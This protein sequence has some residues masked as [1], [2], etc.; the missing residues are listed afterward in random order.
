M[1]T[2]KEFRQETD[3]IYN[4]VAECINLNNCDAGAACCALIKLYYIACCEANLSYDDFALAADKMKMNYKEF[5][6][7]GK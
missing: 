2:E 5:C 1:M 3:K 6:E 7:E 4:L